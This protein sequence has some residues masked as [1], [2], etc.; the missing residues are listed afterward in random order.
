V[1]V[2]IRALGDNAGV[3]IPTV[4]IYGFIIDLTVLEFNLCWKLDGAALGLEQLAVT[5]L[6]P[7][8]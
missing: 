4:D 3:I 2:D 8:I 1:L 7:N 6:T 5:V